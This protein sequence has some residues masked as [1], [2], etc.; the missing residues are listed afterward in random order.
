[1]EQVQEVSNEQFEEEGVFLGPVLRISC[2]EG[3]QFLKPAT[4][5][6]PISLREQQDLNLSP[7]CGSTCDVKVLFLNSDDKQ[8]T[9]IDITDDLVNPPSVDGKFVSFEVERFSR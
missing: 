4:I 7:I 3:V 9:W 2:C 8:K 5:R 6:L 1:M